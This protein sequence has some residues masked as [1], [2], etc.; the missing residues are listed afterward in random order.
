MC[1]RAQ[2]ANAALQ[3][4]AAVRNQLLSTIAAHVPK[5]VATLLQPAAAAPKP[6][7]AVAE[8]APADAKPAAN[9]DAA[10]N[11]NG[12]LSGN[13]HAPE[14]QPEEAKGNGHAHTNGNGHDAVVEPAADPEGREEPDVSFDVQDE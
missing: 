6:A 8:A 4:V 11:G 1:V 9:G 13:G 5:P 12:H 2:T 10:V 7:A 3:Y 14:P